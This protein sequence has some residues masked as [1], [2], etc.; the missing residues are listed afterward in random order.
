M[1]DKL[2]QDP[3]LVQFYDAENGWADDTRY[4]LG[5]ARQAASVLDLG[6]G[7]GLLAAALG[8]AREVWGVDPAGAMLEVARRRDGGSSVTWVEA[9]ARTVRLGRRF[10]LVLMTGHA[11]QCVLT[12]DDQLALC[13][14]IAAHLA[15]DGTFIFDT[16]NPER[17]EWREWGP[18]TS[19]RSFHLPP[20]GRIEAWNDVSHDP[21]TGIVTYG[22][23][24]RNH[25]GRLWTASSSIRFSTKSNV[26][27]CI[28]QAGLHVETWLGDWQGNAWTPASD[29]IIPVG[30]RGHHAGQSPV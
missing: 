26:E 16:R 6:C 22:T 25:A 12:D 23:F 7:T 1:Q 29:E 17:Q 20:H 21:A 27:A 8:P 28:A 24:Y 14:T 2:F 5:L 11:F 9:D 15:P 4:C 3:E 30:R 13:Q 18:D 10:D 19:R